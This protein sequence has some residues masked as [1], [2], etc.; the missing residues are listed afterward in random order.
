MCQVFTSIIVSLGLLGVYAAAMPQQAYAQHLVYYPPP[1]TAARIQRARRQVMGGSVSS[2][3]AGGADARVALTKALG[4]PEHNVIGQLFAAG[5]TQAQPISTPVTSGASVAYNN[6]GHG[7][8]LSKTH[9]AGVLDSF[10]QTATANL[11]NDGVHN[12]DAKAFATQNKLAN[13]LEFQRNGAALDYAH[14]NGHGA[15][16]SHSNIPDFGKQMQLEGRANLWQSLDRNTRL[17]LGG[18][19]SKWISGPLSDKSDYGANL[20]ITHF[21][22]I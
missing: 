21:F 1:P 18:T 20:G 4:T 11:F 9:T 2:N 7:L 17:D 16:L 19:A 14:I 15:T 12:L 5:N 3:A 13:G 8:E 6:N 10:K 22:G